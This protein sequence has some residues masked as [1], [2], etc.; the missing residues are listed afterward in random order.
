MLYFCDGTALEGRPTTPFVKALVRWAT[1]ERLTYRLPKLS[2]ITLHV[3]WLL[4]VLHVLLRG[5]IYPPAYHL[6]W[7]HA[8]EPTPTEPKIRGIGDTLAKDPLPIPSTS[9][10]L[11]W[12]SPGRTNLRAT[13]CDRVLVSAG[14]AMDVHENHERQQRKLFVMHQKWQQ[15]KHQQQPWCRICERIG[16]A[17]QQCTAV[18]TLNTP[19]ETIYFQIISTTTDEYKIASWPAQLVYLQKG[20]IVYCLCDIVDRYPSP[21]SLCQPCGKNE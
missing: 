2:L 12:S 16:H 17:H 11:V 6:L 8:R 13:A 19:W 7:A 21:R 3:M 14:S 18:V 20:A 10:L 9:K 4:L 5:Y 15:R 1:G